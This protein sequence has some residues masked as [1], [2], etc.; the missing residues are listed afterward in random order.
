MKDNVYRFTVGQYNFVFM[1]T[2]EGLF[3]TDPIS[4]AAATYLKTELERR[5]EVPIRY[6]AYSHN[7]VDH[8]LGGDV[9]AAAK[10]YRPP[11]RRRTTPQPQPKPTPPPEPVVHVFGPEC[12]AAASP[13]RTTTPRGLT[14][15]ARV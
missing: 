5:F 14:R 1:V 11:V 4:T 3:V 10:T 7:H 8:V 6:L 15:R 2:D 12:S 13:A 9:L